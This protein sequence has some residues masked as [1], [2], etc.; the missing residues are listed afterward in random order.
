M[1]AWRAYAR[2]GEALDR[3]GGDD[4]AEM[5]RGETQAP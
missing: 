5:A 3:Y 2:M 1:Y 4:G